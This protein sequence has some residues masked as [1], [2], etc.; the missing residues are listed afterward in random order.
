[1]VVALSGLVLQVRYELSWVIPKKIPGVSSTPTLPFPAVYEAAQ[2][3]PAAG[4]KGWEDVW[5]IYYYPHD[6]TAS[7]M[8]RHGT[9]PIET[10]IDFT[11]GKVL[12][13]SERAKDLLEDI[14]EGKFYNAHLWWFLPTH[15]VALLLWLTGVVMAFDPAPKRL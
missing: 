13:V 6:G 2:A 3:V 15:L 1:M 11:T 12:D 7:V 14:H 10:Q 8:V 5:R 9:R 4:V